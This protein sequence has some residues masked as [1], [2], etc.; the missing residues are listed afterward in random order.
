V[1][2]KIIAWYDNIPLL[3]WFL[4]YGKCR[5]CKAKISFLYPAFE[6][7]TGAAF[8]LAFLKILPYFSPFYYYITADPLMV[9]SLAVP[10]QILC[11]GYFVALVFFVF[12]SALIAASRSDLQ[13]MVI[14]Q[15]F[16]LWL[17]PIGL[18]GAHFGVTFISFKM[19]LF[20]A[21]L[22]YLILYF[23]A[24]I[25][26]FFTKKEGVGVGDME[27]LAMIGAFLGPLGVWFA[28][29][30]GSLSGLVIGGL[31]LLIFKK[32]RLTRIP[33]GPFLGLGA[34]LYF[35]LDKFLIKFFFS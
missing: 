2:E 21:A 14:P 28:L 27:L 9:D 12:I 17:V 31:Y 15:I 20:G 7:V 32:D 18:L 35:L 1:C 30:I 25:F 23:I 5:K 19:S 34:F 33:F 6:F 16:S 4:L 29:L 22:G 8:V 26:K 24:F 13:A 10:N 3:S 11:H